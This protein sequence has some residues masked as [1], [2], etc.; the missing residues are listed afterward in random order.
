MIFLP[1]E[2]ILDSYTKVFIRHIYYNH[3]YV[4]ILAIDR[5]YVTAMIMVSGHDHC[6]HIVPGHDG[7]SLSI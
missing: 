6:S 5:D 3:S 1:L 4:A 7:L 2:Q